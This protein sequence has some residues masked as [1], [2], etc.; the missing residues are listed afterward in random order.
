M[1]SKHFIVDNERWWDRQMRAQQGS[2]A[3][4]PLTRKPQADNP[5]EAASAPAGA[6]TNEQA[7]MIRAL[8]NV[9]EVRNRM[10]SWEMRFVQSCKTVGKKFSSRQ[11]EKLGQVYRLRV[12]RKQHY[13][14]LERTS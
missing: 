9:P 8:E 1:S 10:S 6:A 7:R 11:A 3:Q 13:E 14:A 2:R 5:A 12:I 4:Q